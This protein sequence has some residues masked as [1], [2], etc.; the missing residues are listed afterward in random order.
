MKVEWT[1]QQVDDLENSAYMAGI[2]VGENM[3]RTR[4]E[5]ILDAGEENRQADIELGRQLERERIIA[6]I[7]ERTYD[8]YTGGDLCWVMD[9]SNVK[10]SELLKLIEGEDF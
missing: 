6:L 4:M 1:R 8:S 9:A 2:A 7:T 10:K 3:E 5:K